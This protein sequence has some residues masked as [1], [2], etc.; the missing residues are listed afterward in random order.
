M[1]DYKKALDKQFNSPIKQLNE[2]KK[3]AEKLNKKN[4]MTL[5]EYEEYEESEKESQMNTYFDNYVPD[6]Q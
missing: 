2:L 5:E 4:K 6:W 3:E 1:K